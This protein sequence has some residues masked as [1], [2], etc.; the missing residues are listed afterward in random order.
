[1]DIFIPK[2]LLGFVTH[3]KKGKFK[4]FAGNGVLKSKI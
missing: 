4:I 1:M 2:L 3:T